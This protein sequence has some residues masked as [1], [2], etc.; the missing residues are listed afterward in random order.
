MAAITSEPSSEAH[1]IAIIAGKDEVEV[2]GS[3]DVGES[4]EPE[5]ETAPIE[6]PI[7]E[8][9]EQPIEEPIEEPI[10]VS[11]TEGTAEA[12]SAE[13]VVEM[14]GEAMSGD[15]TGEEEVVAQAEGE[16]A[17]AASE[18]VVASV[19][20]VKT[21]AK[22][23]TAP[24]PQSPHA[25]RSR[26]PLYDKRIEQLISDLSARKRQREALKV[27]QVKTCYHRMCV[28]VSKSHIRT[29]PLSTSL[30][31]LIHPYRSLH[32]LYTL[33]ALYTPYT[34]YTPLS[35]STPLIPPIAP[36]TGE[37]ERE[38]ERER[39]GR[40]DE[41]ERGDE[42]SSDRPIQGRGGQSDHRA[43]ER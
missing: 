39:G 21:E 10:E 38:R 43:L 27:A 12:E 2:E 33:I 31:P 26:V 24:L 9:I 22:P 29:I 28:C 1:P 37:R 15:C 5:S 40:C 41:H 16:E 30:I 34:P 4:K 23:S 20:P 6:E 32:P 36:E 25:R 7:E 19:V 35:L 3:G 13:E 14:K 18:S 42:R 8:P 17:N 11:Q